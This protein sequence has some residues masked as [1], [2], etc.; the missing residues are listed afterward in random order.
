MGKFDKVVHDG[1]THVQQ[2]SVHPPFVLVSIMLLTAEVSTRAGN[3]ITLNARKGDP[4]AAAP[5]GIC[6]SMNLKMCEVIMRGRHAQS[7]GC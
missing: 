5:S 2:K 3:T 7:L 1:K 4:A 6:L